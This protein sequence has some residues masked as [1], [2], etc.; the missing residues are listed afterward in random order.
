VKVQ[1]EV[2]DITKDTPYSS[3]TFLVDTN[4]WLYLTYSNANF[5]TDSNYQ[6]ILS[7]TIANYTNYLGKIKK[8]EA[9]LAY[10]GLT[11]AE[12]SHVIEKTECDIYNSQT[13]NSIKL[14]DYR[15]DFPTER[16]NVV[17]EV[18]S[19]WEQVKSIG[20]A[21]NLNIDETVIVNLSTLFEQYPLDGY[22]LFLLET[23]K[24]EGIDK[25]I[26]NDKDF[27]TVSGIKV[28]TSNQVVIAAAQTQNKL[29]TRLKL[30]NEQNPRYL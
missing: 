18:Q 20:I 15:N 3:D 8:N 28:F 5:S 16:V 10:S 25:I 24:K 12:L 13:G 14:K 6:V 23:M 29:R 11:L 17:A 26:T 2:I 1:A 7:R 22:D 21:V 30:P 19:V 9:V 4:V 27:C